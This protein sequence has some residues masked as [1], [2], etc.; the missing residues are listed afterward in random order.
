ML[1]VLYCKEQVKKLI[2]ENYVLAKIVK[3]LKDLKSDFIKRIVNSNHL[4]KGIKNDSV[5]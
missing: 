2:H 4:Q 1:N 3:R 5:R